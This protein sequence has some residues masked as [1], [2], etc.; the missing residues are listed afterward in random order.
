MITMDECRSMVGR[1][2]TLALAFTTLIAQPAL[3]HRQS[4]SAPDVLLDKMTGHWILTGTIG[5]AKSW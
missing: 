5:Y 2:V 3:A 1:G 4:A